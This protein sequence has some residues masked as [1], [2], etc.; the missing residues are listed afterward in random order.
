MDFRAVRE[1]C[2][3]YMKRH[4]NISNC[5]GMNRFAKAQCCEML[6]EYSMDFILEHFSEIYQQV[7][8]SEI[9]LLYGNLL[10]FRY[11]TIQTVDIVL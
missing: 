2:C 1:A 9:I 11:P 5:V 4:M 3:E 10:P 7:S 6:A 8:D